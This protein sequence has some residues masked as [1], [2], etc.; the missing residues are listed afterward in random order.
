MGAKDLSIYQ[1]NPG[2]N[3][4][5]S[6]SDAE[7]VS[8]YLHQL[9]SHSHEGQSSTDGDSP[10]RD[11]E[12]MMLLQLSKERDPIPPQEEEEILEYLCQV[13]LI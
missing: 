5:R 13:G 10:E 3:D 11:F 12:R 6:S 1:E 9:G 7:R 4:Q 8:E 2:K